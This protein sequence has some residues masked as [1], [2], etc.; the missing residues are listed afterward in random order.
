[1]FAHFKVTEHSHLEKLYK[2][3]NVPGVLQYMTE[4]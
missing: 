4:G 2:N 3:R 1:M